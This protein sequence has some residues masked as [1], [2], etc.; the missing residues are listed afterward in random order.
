M[1]DNQENFEGSI[2]FTSTSITK[3]EFN[4]TKDVKKT[5]Y[6]HSFSM[7]LKPKS[8]KPGPVIWIIKDG[9]VID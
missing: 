5:I 3:F 9:K 1:K 8:E 2:E 7:R 6:R 4:K